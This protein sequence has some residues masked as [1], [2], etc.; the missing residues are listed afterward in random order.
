MVSVLRVV[1]VSMCVDMRV[2]RY[3]SISKFV[4]MMP[5]MARTKTTLSD[6]DVRFLPALA[7]PT[8]LAIVRQLAG[9]TGGLR[10]RLHRCCD[11]G[12]PTVSH[13]LRVLRE[14]GRRRRPSGAGPVDLLPA[15]P[16][17][18]NG[19]RSI[20]GGAHWRRAAHPGVGAAASPRRRSTA[21]AAPG[22]TRDRLS[23]RVDRRAGPAGRAS[24]GCRPRR[25]WPVDVDPGERALPHRRCSGADQDRQRAR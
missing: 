22:L 6:P 13:H 19:S 14:A 8:R 18:P 20:A 10:L 17:W 21:D 12:Q 16:G 7:D 5:L 3:L 24:G 15:R 1:G 11:V 2:Y 9:A 25:E 4:D 23:A